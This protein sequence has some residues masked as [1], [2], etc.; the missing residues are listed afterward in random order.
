MDDG[1]QKW[2]PLLEA[3]SF[4]ARAHKH[5]WRKDDQTPYAAHPFR[6][7]L[8]LR[9]VFGID[10][11]EV[12]AAAVLHDTIEDTTTDYDDLVKAFGPRIAGWVALLSKDKRVPEEQREAEY[13]AALAVADWQVKACK[14]ADLFDNLVDLPPSSSAFR[15][16]TI[17]RS[18]DFLE[19]LHAP[20]VARAHDIVTRLLAEVEG[21]V[22]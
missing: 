21:K 11:P 13:R 8:V 17:A 16:R 18:R 3:V 6:V 12:M 10:D 14:L 19:I 22:V 7:C 2:R 9:T 15:K 5:Q 4:A 20:Q 1:Q